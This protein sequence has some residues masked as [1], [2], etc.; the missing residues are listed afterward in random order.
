M[1]WQVYDFIRLKFLNKSLSFY[2]NVLD[3]YILILLYLLIPFL[4][5]AIKSMGVSLSDHLTDT[6]NHLYWKLCS[7]I[8]IFYAACHFPSHGTA[9]SYKESARI[10]WPCIGRTERLYRVRV[11]T[12]YWPYRGLA[13][14]ERGVGSRS[15]SVNHS[16]FQKLRNLGLHRKVFYWYYYDADRIEFGTFKKL[17]SRLY[18]QLTFPVQQIC[19]DRNLTCFT[20]VATG[21]WLKHFLL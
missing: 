4:C 1:P 17:F 20:R 3:N 15:S 18:N 2:L 8:I 12:V 5:D 14:F 10:S 13:V 11:V 7:S 6:L 9:S 19:N 16:F 21:N